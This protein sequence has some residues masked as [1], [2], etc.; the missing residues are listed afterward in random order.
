MRN[1]KAILQRNSLLLR[2]GVFALAMV[3][4]AILLTQTVFAK[5]F[6]A[7]EPQETVHSTEAPTDEPTEPSIEEPTEEP[8]EAPN[9]T[10]PQPTPVEEVFVDLFGNR[11]AFPA[12]EDETVGQFLERNGIVL[13]GSVTADIPLEYAVFG[14]MVITVNDI[15][16]SDDKCAITIPFETIYQESDALKAGTEVILTAGVAGEKLITEQVTYVN[17]KEADRV[18]LSEEVIAE[19]VTQV[20]AVGTG[21]GSGSKNNK[22]V[23]GDGVI[24]TADG[25]VLTFTHRQTF[26][27]T[28]YCRTDVGGE[29]TA[30]GTP[31]RVGVV[32]VDPR[33]IPYGTRMFIVTKDGQYIYGVATAE[34]CGG[35][36]KGN[37]LD[38]FYETREEALQFG[39]RDCDVYFLG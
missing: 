30:I 20:I 14:G 4:T 7:D 15:I 32:A 23:I 5:N 13:T 39:I 1:F 22:P 11:V 27:A 31:T 24:I 16:V 26:K 38:L 6:F 29:I 18:L 21:T 37:R 8:T 3:A 9:L 12:A 2:I 33:V 25:D 10:L 34:D 35:S 19:P 36:I 28:S 17:G